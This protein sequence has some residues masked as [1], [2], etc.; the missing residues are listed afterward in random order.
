[1][2][3]YAVGMSELITCNINLL[4]L[5]L[6]LK[7]HT[8]HRPTSID[9][10]RH[11]FFLNHPRPELRQAP[12][13]AHNKDVGPEVE[14]LPGPRRPW[15]DVGR[16]GAELP[17][18][19]DPILRPHLLTY[20]WCWSRCWKNS[21]CQSLPIQASIWQSG[22]KREHHPTTMATIATTGALVSGVAISRY[23]GGAQMRDIE[24]RLRPSKLL[25]RGHLV[26]APRR[27][28]LLAPAAR[29]SSM[30][31]TAGIRGGENQTH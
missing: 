2:R 12:S 4:F 13:W 17:S 22:S 1:M 14:S 9:P 19:S 25:L 28:R 24:H 30:L 18:L 23:S 11:R 26:P 27:A 15:S 10:H 16:C 29:S 3:V 31:P 5:F 7:K 21:S 20:A 8:P 6:F